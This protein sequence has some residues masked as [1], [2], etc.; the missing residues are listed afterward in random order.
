MSIAC[1]G[2][3][4][5]QP[6]GGCC[7]LDGVICPLHMTEAQALAWINAQPTGVLSN[8]AKNFARAHIVGIAH[9]CRAA[10]EAVIANRGNLTNRAAIEA[11]W[12]A[13]PTYQS[14]VRPV[15]AAVEQRMGIPAGS[16]QC[17]TWKGE[18]GIQ[19]CF[20]ESQATND[21]K[22]ALLAGTAVTVRRAGAL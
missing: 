10:L 7:Y 16:F 20:S 2:N 22:M 19:C 5:G 13:H 18:G 6:E 14:T 4:T 21:A 9:H 1:H 12:I 15:W 17:P 11:A 3:P 8:A